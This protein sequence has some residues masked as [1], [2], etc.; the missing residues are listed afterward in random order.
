M[1]VAFLFAPIVVVQALGLTSLRRDQP[2]I[3]VC[4]LASLSGFRL[5]TDR[6]DDFHLAI[7]AISAIPLAFALVLRGL[8]RPAGGEARFHPAI[9]PAALLLLGLVPFAPLDTLGLPRAVRSVWNASREVRT[10]DAKLV[11]AS[12][13]EAA[14]AIKPSLG[15]CFFTL[16]SEGIW[17]H[18]LDRPSCS[19][20]HHV[21]YARTAEAQQEIVEAL[22]EERPPLIL[23]E[24]GFWSNHIDDVPVSVTNP[25]VWKYVM[26]HYRPDREIDGHKLYRRADRAVSR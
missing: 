19:R 6:A 2:E 8:P 4:L 18:L 15:D 16:T 5:W 13:L 9:A 23:V 3:W 21:V 7:A 12:Y 22:E 14:A 26:I 10:P 25:V 24:N 17:Y 11:P 1:Q 20:F